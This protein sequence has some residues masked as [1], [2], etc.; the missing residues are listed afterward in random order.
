MSKVTYR[1]NYHGYDSDWVEVMDGDGPVSIHTNTLC[2][3]TLIG[4]GRSGGNVVIDLKKLMEIGLPK[5]CFIEDQ[6]RKEV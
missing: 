3:I 4:A 5:G 1:T 6:T 2:S